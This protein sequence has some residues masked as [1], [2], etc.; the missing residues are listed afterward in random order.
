MSTFARRGDLSLRHRALPAV[1]ADPL[2]I[3]T[4]VL[5]ILA[6]AAALLTHLTPGRR[7]STTH[8]P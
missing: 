4:G 2:A 1:S 7:G 3:V 5:A 6:V 8:H